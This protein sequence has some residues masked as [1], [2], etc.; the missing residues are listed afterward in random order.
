MSHNIGNRP[1]SSGFTSQER[2]MTSL[3]SPPEARSSLFNTARSA[4]DASR[5]VRQVPSGDLHDPTLCPF[6]YTLAP[7]QVSRARFDDALEKFNK[8]KGHFTHRSYLYEMANL[9]VRSQVKDPVRAR[10]IFNLLLKR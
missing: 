3:P 4:P 2:G 5:T 1:T 6:Q 9:V 10:L 8:S 7:G